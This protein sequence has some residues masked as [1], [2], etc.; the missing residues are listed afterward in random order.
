LPLGHSAGWEAAVF[1][2]FQ[3]MVGALCSKLQVGPRTAQASDMIGGSTFSYRVWPEHP[4][5][6]EAT[7]FLMEFRANGAALRKKIAAYNEAHPEP[8]LGVKRVI[9]YAGQNVMGLEEPAEDE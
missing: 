6:E 5:Y 7:R 2:H 9:V 1:D 4:Y 3:A 8:E